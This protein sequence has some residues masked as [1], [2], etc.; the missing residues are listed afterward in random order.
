MVPEM[1][2]SLARLGE[3]KDPRVEQDAQAGEEGVEV[4][5]G[6]RGSISTPSP[7]LPFLCR[8]GAHTPEKQ[9]RLG[10]PVQTLGWHRRLMEPQAWGGPLRVSRFLPTCRVPPQSSQHGTWFQ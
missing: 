8:P 4:L 7:I 9:Q 2:S 6:S 3:V 10:A 5:G 1:G